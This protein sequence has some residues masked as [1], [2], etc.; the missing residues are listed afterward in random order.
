MD[1]PSME[2]F[3]GLT[4]G[5]EINGTETHNH[6]EFFPD[7]QHQASKHSSQVLKTSSTFYS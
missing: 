2:V 6:I 3:W 4:T 7:D 5:R 1:S